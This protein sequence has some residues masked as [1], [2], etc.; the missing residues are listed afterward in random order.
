[1]DE[2]NVTKTE[3]QRCNQ[4][5]TE[6]DRLADKLSK[7]DSSISELR[8]KLQSAEDDNCN[9]K[10]DLGAA[11]AKCA[12]IASQI[13]PL[14]DAI[15]VHETEKENASK[16]LRTCQKQT[17]LLNTKLADK[18]QT[19]KYRDTKI[20]SLHSI[21][22]NRERHIKSIEGEVEILAGLSDDK[23]LKRE[24]VA[25]YQKHIKNENKNPNN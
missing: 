9:S 15:K 17:E 24:V 7:K 12:E 16:H 10:K 19:L 21:I 20:R 18:L 23:A 11:M 25:M 14:E 4:L 2:R 1:M 3:T 5:V 13:K 6:V 8:S 22:R